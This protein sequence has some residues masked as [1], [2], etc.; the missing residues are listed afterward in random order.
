MNSTAKTVLIA[1]TLIGGM[2]ATAVQAMPPHAG[3]TCGHG[4]HRPGS[5]ARINHLAER[6]ELSAEQRERVRAIVDKARPAMRAVRDKMQDNRQALRALMQQDKAGEAANALNLEAGRTSEASR[7]TISARGPRLDPIGDAELRRLADARGKL[8]AEMT[9]L[10]ARMKSDIHA[11]LT[12]EQR[13][14][15]K[16]HSEQRRR[17]SSGPSPAGASPESTGLGT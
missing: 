4:Q 2:A 8:V 3:R 14:K 17:V 15:L 12:P 5:E 11:V 13:D 7:A 10:R 16:Q 9:V 6:L 1:A